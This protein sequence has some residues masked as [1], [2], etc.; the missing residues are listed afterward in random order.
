M[1]QI[2]AAKLCQKIYSLEPDGF[3][4]QCDS[5]SA[6]NLGFDRIMFGSDLP[7]NIA[8][9]LTKFR[10]AGFADEE[11]QWHLEKMVANFFNLHFDG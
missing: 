11:L 1:K 4:V 8:T 6:K 7:E 10:T 5:S 3:Q 2:L 9:E